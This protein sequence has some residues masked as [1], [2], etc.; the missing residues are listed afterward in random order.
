MRGISLILLEIR[1]F[2]AIHASP[3]WGRSPES[4]WTI[5][6]PF[7]MNTQL[8]KISMA[9]C[10]LMI[11]I[12]NAHSQEPAKAHSISESEVSVL[13]NLPKWDFT[14]TAYQAEASRLMLEE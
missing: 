11:P 2:M 4:N 9:A 12:A 6:E 8:L 1:S 3:V 13:R 5:F 10:A 14:T 7:A